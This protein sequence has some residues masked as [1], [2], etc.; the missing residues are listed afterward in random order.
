MKFSEMP[1]YEAIFDVVAEMAGGKEH[2]GSDRWTHTESD[3]MYKRVVSRLADSGSVALTKSE[4]ISA[5]ISFRKKPEKKFP[6]IVKVARAHSRRCFWHGRGLGNCSDNVTLDRLICA[7]RGGGY[8]VENCV[9]SCGYHN[10]SR[11]DKTVE[12]FLSTNKQAMDT[13]P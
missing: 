11:G 10:S 12:A 5:W 9:L 6:L 2:P 13:N 4:A 8:S 1:L 3:E 7:V